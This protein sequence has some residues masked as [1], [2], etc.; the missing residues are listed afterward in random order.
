MSGLLCGM[1]H[2]FAFPILISLVIARARDADRGAAM[3][4]FTALFDAG[5]LIGGPVFGAVIE[6]GGYGSMFTTAAILLAMGCV[7]FIV[8]ERGVPLNGQGSGGQDM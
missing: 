4:I 3:A 5:M 6:L 7:V 2:G 1:G 8:W